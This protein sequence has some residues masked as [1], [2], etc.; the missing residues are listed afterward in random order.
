MIAALESGRVPLGNGPLDHEADSRVIV[1]PQDDAAPGRWP[2]RG[3]LDRG[4]GRVK[5]QTGA[6]RSRLW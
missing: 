2:D 5:V 6:E 1:P 3:V 4:P